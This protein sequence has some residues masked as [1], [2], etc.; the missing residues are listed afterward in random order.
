VDH[1]IRYQ[2]DPE[3]REYYRDAAYILMDSRIAQR[4]ARVLKGVRLPVCTGADLTASLLSKVAQ[5]TD[6]IIA[7]GGSTEQAGKLMS[8][9]GMDNLQHYDPPMGFI[10]DA[11][12]VEQ[13]LKF[14]ESASPFRFCLLA[15]GSPQ[16]ESIAHRLR[17]RGVARGLAI[18][19]GASINYITG[20]ETRAPPWIQQLSLEWLYRLLHN[21]RRLAGRYLV[22]GPR[23][24]RYMFRARFIVRQTAQERH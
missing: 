3:F 5:A 14:I 9:Y 16:Q 6:R 7:I 24:F 8:I 21:P 23:I 17:D 13:C 2:E 12:A 18:C 10:N 4:L 15:V 11:D 22:R 19:V 20:V 1:L